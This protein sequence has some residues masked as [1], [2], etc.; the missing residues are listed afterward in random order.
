MTPLPFTIRRHFPQK[1][2]YSDAVKRQRTTGLFALTL[3]L[4]SGCSPQSVAETV[5]TAQVCAES[6]VILGQMRETVVLAATNPAGFATYAT[7][8]GDLL[9]DFNA[10]EPLD[11]ELNVSHEKVSRSVESIVVTLGDP[12]VAALAQLPTQ[13]ADA[14]LGLMEFVEACSL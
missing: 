6:A 7:K 9:D 12:T 14:Q 10:L 1:A 13:I 11:P 8:L 2:R 4:L 5:S 3:A